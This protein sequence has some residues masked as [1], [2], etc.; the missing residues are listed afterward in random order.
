MWP[1]V[2]LRLAIQTTHE[3]WILVS[4]SAAPKPQRR[5]SEAAFARLVAD[6]PLAHEDGIVAPAPQLLDHR[7]RMIRLNCVWPLLPRSPF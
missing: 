5:A 1:G 2:S 4:A 6:M 7:R 3:R